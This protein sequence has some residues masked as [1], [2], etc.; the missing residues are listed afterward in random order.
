MYLYSNFLNENSEKF[1]QMSIFRRIPN[2]RTVSFSMH[3]RE[4]LIK[5]LFITTKPFQYYK[6]GFDSQHLRIILCNVAIFEQNEKVHHTKVDL[7]H[8]NHLDDYRE[9]V[10]DVKNLR[11]KTTTE[12]SN[13]CV[14]YIKQSDFLNSK[15]EYVDIFIDDEDHRKRHYDVHFEDLHLI[16]PDMFVKD[17]LSLCPMEEEMHKDIEMILNKVDAK[18]GNLIELV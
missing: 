15:E 2:V 7:S 13:L 6:T 5:H 8:L 10:K 11:N 18:I 17:T 4:A 14:G 3:P 9:R 12:I 1:E 16:K